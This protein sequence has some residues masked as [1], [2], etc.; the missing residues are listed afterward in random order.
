MDLLFAV[1]ELR[2]IMQSSQPLHFNL[3]V[4]AH[5]SMVEHGFSPD[6][7]DGVDSELVRVL[8]NVLVTEHRNLSDNSVSFFFYPRVFIKSARPLVLPRR[9][10]D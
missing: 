1:V 3:V 10:D 7:P 4:A 5:A 2:T 9:A 6:F 8:V